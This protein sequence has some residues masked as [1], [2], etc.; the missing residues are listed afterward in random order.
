MFL[1]LFYFY[2]IGLTAPSYMGFIQG[3]RK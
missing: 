2:S 1:S 3:R